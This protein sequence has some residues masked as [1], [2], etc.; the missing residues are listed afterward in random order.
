MSYYCILT[1]AGQ[2]QIA[3]ALGLGRTISLTHMAVGDGGGAP[4]T[5]AAAMTALNGEQYRA[6]LNTLS[7]AAGDPGHVIAELVIP[8]SV[9]GWTIREAGLFDDN[10]DMVAVAN[11]PETYKPASAEGG[12][13]E[14][15]VRLHLVMSE[16]EAGVVQLK[17]DPTVVLASRQYV[18]S[19]IVTRA[20][21]VHTHVEY[22]LV[23]HVH[24]EYAPLGHTHE[25]FDEMGWEVGDIRISV[26]STPPNRGIYCNGAALDRL[27]YSDLF[28][29]IGETW[30]AGD[31]STTFNVPDY[32]GVFLRG[33]DDGRGLDSGRV[34]A[35]HQADAIKNHK[36]PA[37]EFALNVL[38]TGTGSQGIIGS[39][40]TATTS[41]DLSGQNTGNN[42]DGSAETRPCNDTVYFYIKY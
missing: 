40:N 35:A 16:A 23:D 11:L 1:E 39:Y 32:R 9:G 41:T 7:V 5:P 29:K 21:L 33:F 10:G 13:T 3:N 31:G 18:D 25:E 38:Q 24:G 8:S 20:P 27:V 34:F 37:L 12:V 42:I 2:A 26:D 14:Q 6:A 15:T 22:A 19:A 17:I 36:H 28:A 30:G 4:I